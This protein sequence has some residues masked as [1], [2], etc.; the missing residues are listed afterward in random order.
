[1]AKQNLNIFEQH[2][3]KLTVGVV[4]LLFLWVIYAFLLGSP[5]KQALNGRMVT[6]SEID[7]T[8]QAKAQQVLERIRSADP[9]RPEVV[10]YL[11][12]Q[13][14]LSRG[15]LAQD[16]VQ[17]ASLLVPSVTPGPPVP[18]VQ[19][20][21]A[22][23]RVTLATLLP[24]D[25]P[26]VAAGRLT[27]MFPP[28]SVPIG[29]E[30]SDLQKELMALE[31]PLDKS[32]VTV[33]V[34]FDYR[35]QREVFL[36]NNYQTNR[37]GFTVS[38]IFLK[39]QKRLSNGEWG[40]WEEVSEYSQYHMDPEPELTL[41]TDDD[42]REYVPP[43]QRNNLKTWFGNLQEFQS[44]LV[45][46]PMPGVEYGEEWRPPFLLDLIELYPEEIFPEPEIIKQEKKKK[47][48]PLP[49]AREDL[50]LAREL[51]AEG[52][53]GIAQDLAEKILN[54]AKIPK[55]N[56][57]KEEARALLDEIKEAI[58][59]RDI[60]IVKGQGNDNEGEDEEGE[61]QRTEDIFFAHD[62][63]AEP[64]ATY[65]YQL[66]VQ[67][68]NQYATIA[69]RLKDPR[70]ALKVYIESK[71]SPLTDPVVIPSQQ[72]VFLASAKIESA[73]FDI[74]QWFRGMW[75]R[76]KFSA[77]I[78]EKIGGPKRVLIGRERTN[79][80]FET[81]ARLVEL[82]AE[83]P[84]IPRK[85]QRDGSVVLGE[86]KTSAAALC[87]RDSGEVFELVQ[88]VGKSDKER[89]LIDEEMKQAKRRKRGRSRDK[90]GRQPPSGGGRGRGGGG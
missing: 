24:P 15:P 41:L 10:D 78:G 29:E 16:G 85:K 81:G 60:E 79:V 18:D 20:P 12:E 40:P 48:P 21:L 58:R 28:E 71:W 1:M 38:D 43:G 47:L 62:I 27:A 33:A 57:I 34:R 36:N 55:K 59:K 72:R 90:Q 83:K 77:K 53:L 17:L 61:V 76:E 51:F 46:P 88:A 8:V 23:G 35:K 22:P 54:T 82:I 65:R 63:T 89:K 70:D 3:E 11:E 30:L 19:G 75:V 5:N 68:F 4:A 66:K 37:F 45:R 84:Y 67:A 87:Q 32:W 31:G 25:Q 7:K 74:Y 56:R 26:T 9:E 50:V 64:G 49:Q 2:V 44:D 39:R 52:K 80:Q 73:Q 69:D 42:G 14:E 86:P 6:P 13:R